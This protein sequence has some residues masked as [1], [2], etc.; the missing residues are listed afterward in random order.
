MTPTPA[1]LLLIHADAISAGG[2]TDMTGYT[3]DAG[4]LASRIRMGQLLRKRPGLCLR[5]L[6][7]EWDKERIVREL[8]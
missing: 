4:V 7:E 6:V 5:A 2:I 3:G 8:Y 1:D